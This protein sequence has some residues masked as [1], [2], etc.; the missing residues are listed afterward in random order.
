MYVH[1]PVQAMHILLAAVASWFVLAIK[2]ALTACTY[3]IQHYRL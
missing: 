2:V 3:E 1:V